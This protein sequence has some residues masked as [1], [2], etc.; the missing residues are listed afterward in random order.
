MFFSEAQPF[1]FQ[2]RFLRPRRFFSVVYSEHE[3][4]ELERNRNHSAAARW[5][6]NYTEHPCL[7]VGGSLKR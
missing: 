4:L 7:R 5:V 1:D 2:A 6:R 3:R